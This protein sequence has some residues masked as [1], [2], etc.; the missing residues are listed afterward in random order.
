MLH[1]TK[2]CP[3]N[4]G[5]HLNKHRTHYAYMYFFEVLIPF[6]MKFRFFLL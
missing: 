4:I 2:S 5:Q 1:L 3:D 6:N